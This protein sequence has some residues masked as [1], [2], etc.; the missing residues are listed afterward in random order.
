MQALFDSR[1]RVDTRR[2]LPLCELPEHT[3]TPTRIKRI[4]CE[5]ELTMLIRRRIRRTEVEVREIRK[6]C[7]CSQASFNCRRRLLGATT[8]FRSQPRRKRKLRTERLQRAQRQRV[9]RGR[10]PCACST[11]M[12]GAAIMARA[13][14]Q[15]RSSTGAT[16]SPHRHEAVAVAPRA[17]RQ[18]ITGLHAAQQH[19]APQRHE[20]QAHGAA[21]RS[22]RGRD[23]APPPTPRPAASRRLSATPCCSAAAGARRRQTRASCHGGAT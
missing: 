11:Q 13:L 6:R 2:W 10:P 12:P 20:A 23:R 8:A 14:R 9:V 21:A 3:L 22:V 4:A 15:H 16:Q 19:A 17:Q 7:S 1:L 18:R 5:R